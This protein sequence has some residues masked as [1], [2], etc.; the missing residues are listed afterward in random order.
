MALGGR[1]TLHYI[2]ERNARLFPGREAVVCGGEKRITWAQLDRNVNRLANALLDLGVTEGA[3]VGVMLR[4]SNM[5]VEAFAAVAKVGA[6]SF[7]VNY[8][9][10]AV[11]LEHV[12]RDAEAWAL[13]CNPEYEGLVES[14][15]PDLPA[16]ERVI[17]CPGA[18][19]PA[20]LSWDEL[21][22]GSS[23]ARPEPP[24]GPGGDDAVLLF[25]TGGTTGMPRGVIWTWGSISRFL[26]YN[27]VNTMLKNVGLLSEASPGSM[28]RFVRAM[29]LPLAGSGAAR[30]FYRRVLCS[31]TAMEYVGSLLERAVFTPPGFGPAVN[32]IGGSLRALVASPLM[33]GAAWV[34]CVPVM[35]AGGT[36]HFLGD[37][38]RFD[39]ASVWEL[40]EREHLMLVVVVGDAYVAPMMECLES[41]RY[42]LDDLLVL[43]T[44]AVKL[45]PH[46][47]EKLHEKLP[48][49]MVLDALLATEGG[50]AI[51]DVTATGSQ[52][53]SNT[54]FSVR[55]G[56]RF[57]V[58]VLDG[59]G[60][61]VQPGSGKVG[62]LAYGGPQSQGYWRDPAKTAE[63]YRRIDGETW[64]TMGDLCTVNRDGTINLMG[65]GQTCINSG[66]EKI[67]P[68]EIENR[69]MC[70]EK[71][72][73]VAVVGVP[74]PRWGE[75]V[76][77]VVEP[78][79]SARG[80]GGLEE[81]LSAFLRESLAD[82]K[83]PKHWVLVESLGRSASGKL[84][85]QSVR[86]VAMERLGIPYNRR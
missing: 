76:T 37:S 63:T 65:R 54:R 33:H 86:E 50:G 38:P 53:A 52:V 4:N 39:A 24:W 17:V 32:R 22:G 58:R 72:L 61:F 15:R 75:A 9:Y 56:G 16:L 66:G 25:Y 5:F 19:D 47:K 2:I 26:G 80:S 67:F 45:S 35:A 77:A 82:F 8:R 79:E 70:H 42:D 48:N 62:T 85:Y 11:E 40:A 83:C 7:N 23:P 71:V 21:L 1:H 64:I 73:D 81:E 14:I 68:I 36:I 28:D 31:G 51:F 49:A 3:R 18:A 30:R 43:G 6:T 59:E 29:S 13:V 57:P 74:H 60:G 34:A 55:Y 41:R 10:Q 27:V 78:R 84:P 44:G 69:L 46:L 12:L 20:N